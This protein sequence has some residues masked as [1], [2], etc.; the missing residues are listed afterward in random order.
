[1]E[2]ENLKGRKVY[3]DYGVFET[4]D[5]GEIV[6]DSPDENGYVDL[7]WDVN[8]WLYSYVASV[9][10]STIHEKGWTSPNGSSIGLFFDDDIEKKGGL[11]FKR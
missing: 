7:L 11:A 4:R 5:V 2:T 10:I 6:S 3:S 8:D 1:M 9:H